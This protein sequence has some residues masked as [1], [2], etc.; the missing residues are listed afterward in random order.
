MTRPRA[1]KTKPFQTG[2]ARLMTPGCEM[3]K[4]LSCTSQGDATIHAASAKGNRIAL[5]KP[6]SE[7]LRIATIRCA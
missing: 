1:N 2:E 5:E 6:A 7:K 3:K 4:S